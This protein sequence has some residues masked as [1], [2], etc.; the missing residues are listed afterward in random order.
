MGR[1]HPRPGRWYKR[2]QGLESKSERALRQYLGLDRDYG[3]IHGFADHDKSTLGGA[4]TISFLGQIDE[5]RSDELLDSSDDAPVWNETLG[6]SK[7]LYDEGHGSVGM[8]G[9]GM[10]AYG[11]GFLAVFAW[12]L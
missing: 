12:V 8:S 1:V 7:T 6:Y 5:R 2:A 9:I 10:W 3:N 11:L 4:I